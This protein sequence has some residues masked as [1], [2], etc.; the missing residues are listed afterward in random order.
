MYGDITMEEL[1]KRAQQKSE[2]LD[3]ELDKMIESDPQLKHI[4]N[5]DSKFI[6][7]NK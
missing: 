2:N 3:N 7:N 6:K 4:H 1:M 5:N